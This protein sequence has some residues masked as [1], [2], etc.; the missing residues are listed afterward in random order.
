MGDHV[1]ADVGFDVAESR[2]GFVFEAGEE[3]WD[4]PLF[5][6]GAREGV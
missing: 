6:I 1:G 2:F 3:S 5:K 4:D